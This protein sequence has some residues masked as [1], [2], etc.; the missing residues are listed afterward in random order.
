MNST[1]RISDFYDWVSGL[2]RVYGLTSRLGGLGFGIE[3]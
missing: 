3:G 1:H 2:C